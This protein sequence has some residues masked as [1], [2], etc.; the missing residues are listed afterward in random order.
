[1][2]YE[3]TNGEKTTNNNKF[4]GI[5]G[6]SGGNSAAAAAHLMQFNPLYMYQ[7]QMAQHL[8]KKSCE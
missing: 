1:M 5:Q 3:V 6:M 8:G 4:S 2:Y 7:L